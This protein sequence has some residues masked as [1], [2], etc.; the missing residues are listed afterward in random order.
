[1]TDPHLTKG[2]LLVVD[3]FEN[4]ATVHQIEL[5]LFQVTAS[6][7]V[8]AYFE[9]RMLERCDESGIEIRRN[10]SSGRTYATTEPIGD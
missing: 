7:V 9:V 8:G 1:M 5:V 2:T 3:V 4:E 6:D 10:D